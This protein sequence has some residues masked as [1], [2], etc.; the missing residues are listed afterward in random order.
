[1]PCVALLVVAFRLSQ[2]GSEVIVRPFASLKNNAML[3]L[4]RSFAP[5]PE[6][7]AGPASESSPARGPGHYRDECFPLPL[8]EC[9]K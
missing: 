9:K 4:A 2:R 8:I 3:A 1:M 7:V 6:R 5:Q